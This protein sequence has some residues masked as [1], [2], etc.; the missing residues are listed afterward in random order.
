MMFDPRTITE[1]QARV[2]I[3]VVTITIVSILYAG[4]IRDAIQ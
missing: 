2:L 4:L 1:R 3:F